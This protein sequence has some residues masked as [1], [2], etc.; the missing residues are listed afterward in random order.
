MSGVVG[1]PPNDELLNQAYAVWRYVEK[2]TDEGWKREAAVAAAEEHFG[3]KR[4][5]VFKR[6]WLVN[7]SW[8]ILATLAKS[9]PEQFHQVVSRLAKAGWFAE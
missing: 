7:E 2:R 4:A 3:L 8:V 5:T 1:R 9:A 6:L